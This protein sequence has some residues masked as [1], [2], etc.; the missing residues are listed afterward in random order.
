MWNRTMTTEDNNDLRIFLSAVHP[1]ASRPLALAKK[2]IGVGRAHPF[3]VRRQSASRIDPFANACV[4]A[5]PERRGGV[6]AMGEMEPKRG[7]RRHADALVGNM[8][9]Q[10]RAGG[11]TR[12]DN[13][14]IRAARGQFG[15]ARIIFG[16]AAAMIVVDV[17]G[18]GASRDDRGVRP[19]DGCDNRDCDVAHA[20]T[21]WI[22]RSA[23][24][25]THGPLV[26]NRPSDR[27]KDRR[28]RPYRARK[29]SLIVLRLKRAFCSEAILKPSYR[30]R[31]CA[32][33]ARCSYS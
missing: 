14:D 7:L 27:R 16:D 18:F 13:P 12:A 30:P 32:D 24:R 31:L 1:C 3:E 19:S 33:M 2:A 6:G 4:I 5:G 26:V 20:F 29:K 23:A 21:P 9:E 17:D 10:H 25:V 15:P 8:G 28:L 22:E 11:L